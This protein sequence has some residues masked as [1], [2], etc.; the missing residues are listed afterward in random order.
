MNEQE[1]QLVYELN[2][3]EADRIFM[4]IEQYC[5]HLEAALQKRLQEIERLNRRIKSLE[6]TNKGLHTMYDGLKQYSDQI[7]AHN[8]SLSVRNDDLIKENAQLDTYALTDSAT[9]A[10]QAKRIKYL[11]MV[12]SMCHS[13]DEPDD[14]EML[15]Q[16]TAPIA[17]L[18]SLES[19]FNA[20]EEINLWYGVEDD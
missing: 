18:Y 6:T 3:T 5:T 20:P 12:V 15:E 17:L 13:M 8:F 7:A 2:S 9:I 4:E 10:D 16:Y 14:R 19:D 11:E 1:Q